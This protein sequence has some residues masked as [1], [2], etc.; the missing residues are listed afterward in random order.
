[1]DSSENSVVTEICVLP[2]NEID[3]LTMSLLMN[4]QSYN[5]IMHKHNPDKYRDLTE[6]QEKV[7]K[8]RDQIICITNDKLTNP[9]L[10]ITSDIDDSFEGYIKA[11]IQHSEQKEIAKSNRFNT[12]DDEDEMF[13]TMDEITPPMN[14]SYWGKHTVLKQ[15]YLTN[16]F[17]MKPSGK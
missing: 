17:F 10:Q 3:Q 13:G 1:M 2:T 9:D 4:K 8:Y 15:G 5:K 16:D 14:K 12:V 7:D 11:I 6:F